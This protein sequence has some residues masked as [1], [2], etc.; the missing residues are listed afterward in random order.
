MPLVERLRGKFHSVVDN[1]RERQ[2]PV[3]RHLVQRI[4]H[5]LPRQREFHLQ[6][7]ALSMRLVDNRQNQKL[8]SGRQL[9]VGDVYLPVL[10]RGQRGRCGSPVLA[11]V[12]L[13]DVERGFSDAHLPADIAD[14]LAGI[15]L[16]QRNQNLP[17]G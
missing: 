9:I 13:P 6:R 12:L 17:L 2:R 16:L 14:R 10:P 3:E 7:D 8:P 15:S 1:F 5:A 4:D 11:D